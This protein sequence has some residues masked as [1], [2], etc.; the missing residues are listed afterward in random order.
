MGCESE[1]VRIF[2][3]YGPRIHP[4][5]GRVVSNFIIQALR[6]GDITVYGDGR[7]RAASATWMIS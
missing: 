4:S 7:K 3:T 2:N 5:D 1:V 6:G